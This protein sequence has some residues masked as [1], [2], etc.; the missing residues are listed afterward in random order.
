[1]QSHSKTGEHFGCCYM[2]RAFPR[3]FGS[4]SQPALHEGLGARSV[5]AGGLASGAP[6]SCN[7]SHLDLTFCWILKPCCGSVR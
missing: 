5:C 3:V 6:A 7:N 2:L 1:M 4:P